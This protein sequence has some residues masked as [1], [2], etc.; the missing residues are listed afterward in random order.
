MFSKSNK[1]SESI[2]K[3]VPAEANA[4]VENSEP[5][6]PEPLRDEEQRTRSCSYVG[7]TLHIKGEINVDESL[8]IE[9]RVEGLIKSGDK[10]LTVGKQGR[11]SA[12]IHA[13]IVEVRGRIEGDV[14]GE[15][16]VHLYSTAIVQGTIHCKRLVVD[17]GAVFDGRIAMAERD[18]VAPAK[19][20][21]TLA[22][23]N[24]PEDVAQN[25]A[26]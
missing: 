18:K 19:G 15:D 5:S 4:A 11:V 26:S 23:S 13:S 20:T 7:P 16:V 21:L 22:S 2:E 6:R 3:E 12:E 8:N 25:V 10:K 1:S 9:G 17:D 24:D 14:H